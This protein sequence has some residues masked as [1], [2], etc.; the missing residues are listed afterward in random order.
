MRP[1]ETVRTG[2]RVLAG[3]PATGEQLLQPVLATTRH[4]ADSTLIIEISQG[5]VTCTA[6]HPFWVAGSGWMRGRRT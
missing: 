5:V 6:A 3:E 2:E 1:I 4:Q